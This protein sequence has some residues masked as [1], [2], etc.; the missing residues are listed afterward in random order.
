M[1]D[2]LNPRL[3]TWVQILRQRGLVLRKWATVDLPFHVICSTC[4]CNLVL[5][6][7]HAPSPPHTHTHTHTQN[8]RKQ[9]VWGGIVLPVSGPPKNEGQILLI[10]RV[11]TFVKQLNS[12]ATMFY[13]LL[14][15]SVGAVWM[16][17]VTRLTFLTSLGNRESKYSNFYSSKWT[18]PPPPRTAKPRPPPPSPPSITY[19]THLLGQD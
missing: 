16:R 13:T 10:F 15:L 3:Q 18:T 6:S 2:I 19:P 5:F 8:S 7:W 12:A 11:S 1:P 9:V 17:K 14:Y 4:V